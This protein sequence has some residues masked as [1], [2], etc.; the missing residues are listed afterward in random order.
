MPP[1]D[2][3]KI[4]LDITDLKQHIEQEIEHL[5]RVGG[6]TRT[7]EV[8]VRNGKVTLLRTTRVDVAEIRD[9]TA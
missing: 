1:I 9:T 6:G 8:T 4:T 7:F 3:V 2:A 5:R